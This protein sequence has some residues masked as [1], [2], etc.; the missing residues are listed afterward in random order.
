MG[1][2]KGKT[3][4]AKSDTV[5]TG[6]D[7]ITPLPPEILEFHAIVTLGIDVM[8]VNGLP[9]LVSYSRV[10]KFGITTELVNMKSPAIVVAIILILRVYAT[11]GFRVEFIAADNGFA[12]LQQDEEFLSLQV[13]MNVTSE[14]DHEPFSER[15]IQTVKEKCRMCLSLVPFARL[16]RRMTNDM[17]YTQTF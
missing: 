8:K 10:I 3:T 16:P 11:R 1:N 14:D 12:S 4:R 13:I 5:E 2:L 6:V 17:V 15:F 7:I 9:F